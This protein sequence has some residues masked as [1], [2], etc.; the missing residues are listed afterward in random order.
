[1]LQ[2]GTTTSTITARGEKLYQAEKPLNPSRYN[3]KK[4]GKSQLLGD[5][6]NCQKESIKPSGPFL[7][8]LGLGRREKVKLRPRKEKQKNNASLL[9]D[10]RFA[11]EGRKE[12]PGKMTFHP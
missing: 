4:R 6:K 5:L 3:G 2:L 9:K 12:G 10:R 11:G 7:E 1:M 8:G